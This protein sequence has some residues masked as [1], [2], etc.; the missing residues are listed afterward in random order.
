MS[1]IYNYI[2]NI[3]DNYE[4]SYE[5]DMWNE[6]NKHKKI[7]KINKVIIYLKYSVIFLTLLYISSLYFNHSNNDKISFKVV[8]NK[9]TNIKTSEIIKNDILFKNEK[10]FNHN[11]NYNN[12]KEYKEYEEN[13]E[14]VEYANKYFIDEYIDENIN[15]IF[16]TDSEKHIVDINTSINTNIIN[17]IYDLNDINNKNIKD[18]LSFL[19][20]TS[21][22]SLDN[23]SYSSPI[24]TPATSQANLLFFIPNAFSPNGDGIND[25]FFIIKNDSVNINFQLLVYDR[26]GN[27]IF[28]T[29]NP[30]YKW[31]CNNC[32]EGLYFWILKIQNNDGTIHVNK[33]QVFLLK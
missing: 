1:N 24:D 2:K 14:C 8:E 15:N 4:F 30:N 19:D 20:D 17:D 6:F 7:K 25:E 31:I 11:V 28:E 33:G 32:K 16:N 12:Y 3:I 5:D 10:R 9:I 13:K 18:I 27:L 22:Y 29:I 23:Y 21:N 26:W